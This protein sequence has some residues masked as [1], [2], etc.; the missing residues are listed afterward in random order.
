LKSDLYSNIPIDRAEMISIKQDY[1]MDQYEVSNKD[2]KKAAIRRECA[3][4]NRQGCESGPYP[5]LMVTQAVSRPLQ[6]N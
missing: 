3:I 1:L 2:F 6:L 4:S 5:R